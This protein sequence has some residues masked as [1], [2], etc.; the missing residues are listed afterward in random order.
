M[1][2][3]PFLSPSILTQSEICSDQSNRLLTFVIWTRNKP[4]K[5]VYD[6]YENTGETAKVL[7]KC[8][9]TNV[10]ENSDIKIRYIFKTP[11]K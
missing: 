11:F 4:E 9:L 5:S 10:F 8:G 6:P 1:D 7:E 2:F 3:E